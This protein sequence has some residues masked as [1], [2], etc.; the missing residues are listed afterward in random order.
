MKK[1]VIKKV[2]HGKLKGQFRFLLVAENG[3]VVAVSHPETYTQKHSL[4]ETLATNF[5]NFTVEDTTI[6]VEETTE[7]EEVEDARIEAQQ[8]SNTQ[9]DEDQVSEDQVRQEGRSNGTE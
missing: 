9:E 8:V 1:A 4:L 6:E 7:I 3:E 5:P 2:T